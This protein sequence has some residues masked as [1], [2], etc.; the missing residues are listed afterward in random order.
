MAKILMM[1]KGSFGEVLPMI[2]VSS[3]LAQRGH[4]VKI[5]CA[6]S[7]RSYAEERRIE[8]EPLPEDPEIILRESVTASPLSNPI[9]IIRF[10]RRFLH[11]PA[12]PQFE[13]I[14]QLENTIKDCDLM[15]GSYTAMAW[16]HMA[17]KLQRPW[18]TFHPTP[19]LPSGKYANPIGPLWWHLLPKGRVLNYLTHRFWYRMLW[20]ATGP[21]VN[22]LRQKYLD[23][24]PLSRSSAFKYFRDLP[25]LIAVSPSLF[26]SPLDWPNHWHVTGYPTEGLSFVPPLPKE[27]EAFLDS[28][29]PP[30]FIGFSSSPISDPLFWTEVVLPAIDQAGCRAILG[31]GW[32]SMLPSV[33]SSNVLV[34]KS[35]SFRRLFPRVSCIVHACGIGTLSEAIISG[36]PSLGIPIF[37]EQ[38][39][40]AAQAYRLGLTPRPCL[41]RNLT[42]RR[43]SRMLRELILDTKY[44]SRNREFGKQLIC[45]CGIPRACDVVESYLEGRG[46]ISWVPRMLPASAATQ[47][48]LNLI[49]TRS[50]GTKRIGEPYAHQRSE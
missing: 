2:Y 17:E 50:V 15:I 21:W 28:G 26:P 36:T 29:E 39:F 32:S 35:V 37:G 45:E 6:K 1:A 38:K 40:I 4:N 13:E 34:V 27:V 31:A 47:K 11:S 7:M 48:N 14:T 10:L 46:Q 22:E 9:R 33:E 8:F 18:I 41:L 30:V 49:P 42:A 25:R 19:S 16:A 5:V 44:R 12:M 20:E 23:L 3:G 24:P 43:L